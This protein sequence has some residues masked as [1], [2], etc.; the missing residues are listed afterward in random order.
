FAFVILAA[1]MVEGVASPD[2]TQGVMLSATLSIFAIPFLAGIAAWATA[3][4][5]RPDLIEDTDGLQAPEGGVL[6][7][8]YGRVGQLIGEMLTRHGKT[9]VAVDANPASVEGA[10]RLGL[11]VHYG[12]ASRSELL[13]RC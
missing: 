7:V 3:R 8:G 11:P 6:I 13:K 4:G 5:D 10:R 1:G 12:D 2:F 9:F